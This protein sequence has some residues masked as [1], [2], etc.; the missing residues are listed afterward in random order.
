MRALTADYDVTTYAWKFNLPACMRLWPFYF[1]VVSTGDTGLGLG[2]VNLVCV[3]TERSLLTTSTLL[4][5]CLLGFN[6]YSILKHGITWKNKI[7]SVR[8][9]TSLERSA[10]SLPPRMIG[11]LC[12]EKLLAGLWHTLSHQQISARRNSKHG[13]CKHPALHY[14]FS[15]KRVTSRTKKNHLARR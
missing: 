14:K 9:Q 1:W 8:G 4:F 10:F 7:H 3:A 2:R 13:C 11:F 12:Q 6:S 15:I 5:F